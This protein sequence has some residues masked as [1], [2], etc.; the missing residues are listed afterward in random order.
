MRNKAF[1]PKLKEKHDGV[2]KAL[3]EEIM[4]D[5]VG[6]KLITNNDKEDS[7]DFSD[8]FWDQKYQLPSGKEIKVE[9]EMKNSKWWG[10][11]WSTTR[12]FRYEEIDIPH[13]KSKNQAQLHIVIS[14]CRKLAFLVTRKA[15][16]E[17]L[18][19]A[20]GEPKVKKT[21]Y[22][23]DGAPYFSTPVSKGIFVEKGEDGHWHRW[24][25]GT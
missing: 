9:P 5:M 25:K 11:Q 19:T 20:G 24:K 12:P 15:M 22:E 2:G 14:T 8:G 17:Q 18:A 3:A 13:R 16:D 6:A 7:G 23:P 1:D 4:R 10:K 21:I